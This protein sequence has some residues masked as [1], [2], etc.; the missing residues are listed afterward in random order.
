MKKDLFLKWLGTTP[1]GQAHE[2][3]WEAW[4]TATLLERESCAIVCDD[5]NA[6]YKWP[7][8]VAEKVASQWCADR[9]RAREQYE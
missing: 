6:N 9:I 5:I 3:A 4:K 8:S 2:F 1:S 7:D